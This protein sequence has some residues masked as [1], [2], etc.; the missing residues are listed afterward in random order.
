MLKPKFY[1]RLQW[2]FFISQP[3]GEKG[4]FLCVINSALKD[5]PL[6]SLCI[7]SHYCSL[8][9]WT[10]GPLREKYV[11]IMKVRKYSKF[12]VENTRESFYLQYTWLNDRDRTPCGFPA[13]VTIRWHSGIIWCHFHVFFCRKI[14]ALSISNEINFKLLG[15]FHLCL[16]YVAS[17]IRLNNY[18][19]WRRY[20]VLKLKTLIFYGLNSI[21]MASIRNLMRTLCTN[22]LLFLG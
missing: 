2:S 22:A 19:N 4:H 17:I 11:K 9:Y 8:T 18:L 7:L 5:A 10:V 6:R 16:S 13:R 14:K 1:N 15:L 3:N 20:D 12:Y 21:K